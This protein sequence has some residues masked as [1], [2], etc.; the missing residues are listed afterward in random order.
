MRYVVLAALVVLVG[1][2]GVGQQDDALPGAPG[3]KVED[4]LQSDSPVETLVVDFIAKPEQQDGQPLD[5]LGHPA[6]RS[7]THCRSLPA[8]TFA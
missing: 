2:Y 8:T 7:R 5:P 4:G 3:E 1:G 6:R